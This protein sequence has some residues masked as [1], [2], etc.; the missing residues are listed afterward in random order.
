MR[1]IKN[2]LITDTVADLCRK[3]AY[4]L[5]LDVIKSLNLAHKQEK[6]LAKEIIK[7]TLENAKTASKGVFPL[8]Q[9]TGTAILFVEIGQQLQIEG[10]LG[11]GK[12][13]TR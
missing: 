8:C 9:D 2:S 7:L 13:R 11:Q 10:S 4:L 1:V 12:R 5:P 6:G 3:A